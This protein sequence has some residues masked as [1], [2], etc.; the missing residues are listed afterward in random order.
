[1]L[2]NPKDPT[3]GPKGYVKCN[4]G[5]NAKGATIPTHLET[6]NEED[7]EGLASLNFFHI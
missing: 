6:D 2:T 4:I 1:M 7:I 3:G 5:I